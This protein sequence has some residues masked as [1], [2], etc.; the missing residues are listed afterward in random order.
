MNNEQKSKRI[1]LFGLPPWLISVVVI[2]L[3]PIN[4]ILL[5]SCWSGRLIPSDSSQIATL[6]EVE[7]QQA[8]LRAVKDAEIAEPAEISQELIPIVDHNP[9][10]IWL[11]KP[12][13][14][15][16]LVVTWTSQRKKDDK[17]ASRNAEYDVWVTVAPE[18]KNFC[19][20]LNLSSRKLTLR[21][22]QLLGLPPNAGKTVFK[23]I[24]VDPGN[25]F[26]PAPDP[27]ITDREAGLG[28]PKSDKF[29]TVDNNHISWFN[30]TRSKS[31]S[32]GGY[33]W[34][35]LGY[36]YDWGNP[37]SEIGLSEFV[38]KKGAPIQIH[39]VVNADAYC[40]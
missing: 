20:K 35:R 34:T 7:L 4:I 32:N 30:K 5:K 39:S 19:R 33:P 6:P 16:I 9:E 31:Y 1:T 3:F 18:L 8:Y 26:R 21:L 10:L 37:T 2:I 15:R 23:E 13:A 38:I 12:G 28:F 36:T 29:L 14:S 22:E 11:G 25:L 40:N 17:A 24:W 27:E